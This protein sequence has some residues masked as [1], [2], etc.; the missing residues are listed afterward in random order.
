MLRRFLPVAVSLLAVACQSENP[1]AADTDEPATIAP[2]GSAAQSSHAHNP[3]ELNQQLAELRAATARFHR[4]DVAV[5]AGY[6]QITPCVAHPTL[7][8]QGFHY[9]KGALI[10]GTASLLEPEL[11]TYEPRP[12]GLRL[13]GVEYII[14]FAFLPSDATPPTL[15]GQTFHANTDLGLWALHVWVWQQNPSGM[16]ADWN[17][18]VSC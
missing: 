14:P 5:A 7:G 12:N 3:S 15:L 18:K 13:V 1:T 8:A 16:F 11:L 4:L 10:D 2:T 6:G 17:P 9:G